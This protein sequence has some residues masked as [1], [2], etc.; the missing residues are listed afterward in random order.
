MDDLDACKELSDAL[1]LCYAEYRDWRK[2]KEAIHELKECMDKNKENKNKKEENK[3][4]NK[5]S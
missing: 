3:N 4:K 2:C 5:S 1:S